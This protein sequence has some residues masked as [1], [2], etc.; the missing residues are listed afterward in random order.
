MALFGSLE[1]GVGSVPIRQATAGQF[2]T[3]GHS[4]LKETCKCVNKKEAKE[5]ATQAGDSF[6]VA[7][8]PWVQ[9]FVLLVS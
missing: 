4:S 5:F 3:L 7:I 2:L 9:C 8:E 6:P 1:H